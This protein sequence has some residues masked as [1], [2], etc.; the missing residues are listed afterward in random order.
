[1]GI[2]GVHKALKG[3]GVIT[4]LHLDS[5]AGLKAGVDTHSLLHKGAR[6]DSTKV[7]RDGDFS[8]VV[9]FCMKRARMVASSGVDRIFV[10]DGG[11]L[12]S[13]S[14]EE[15]KRLQSRAKHK[16]IGD[17]KFKERD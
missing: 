12:P 3:A 2:D 4:H 11:L 16:T 13:K 10:F 15:S 7:V 17:E 9:N 1:M 6:S 14:G 5:F 8:M